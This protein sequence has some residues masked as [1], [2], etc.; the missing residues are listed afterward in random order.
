GVDVVHV[1]ARRD[2]HP[3]GADVPVLAR[4]DERGAAVAVDTAQVGAVAQGGGEDLVVALGPGVEVGRILEIVRGVHVGARLDQGQR[5]G[6]GLVLGGG[7][8]RRAV[9]VAA[10]L[11][12][13]ATGEQVADGGGVVGDGR[14]VEVGVETVIDR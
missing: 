11:R 1:H 13:G 3:H 7:D 10:R 6:G 8:Q 5:G 9:A 2:E 4:R 14:G 12:I